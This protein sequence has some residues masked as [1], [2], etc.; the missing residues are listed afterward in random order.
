VNPVERSEIVEVA[1][2][3]D[4]IASVDR[5]S[6]RGFAGHTSAQNS[7]RPQSLRAPAPPSIAPPTR[8]RSMPRP[9]CEPWACAR[10][11]CKSS[12]GRSGPAAQ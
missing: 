1:G 6:L 7:G 5:F 9:R 4:R 2:S 8:F 10:V 11:A 3:A 12:R